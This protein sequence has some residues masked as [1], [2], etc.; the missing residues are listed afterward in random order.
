MVLIV[1]G[2]GLAWLSHCGALEAVAATF[3]DLEFFY[4]DNQVDSHVR[5][6]MCQ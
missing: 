1:A 6:N 4:V 3:I 5:K 2:V